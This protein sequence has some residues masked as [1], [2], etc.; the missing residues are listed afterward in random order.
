MKIIEVAKQGREREK[1]LKVPTKALPYFF[2]SILGIPSYWSCQRNVD[3]S[4]KFR[5]RKSLLKGGYL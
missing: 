1:G 2:L 5:V 4:G 3:V